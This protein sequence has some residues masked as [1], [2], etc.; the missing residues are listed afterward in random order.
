MKNENGIPHGEYCYDE[1]GLC[2]H[3]CINDNEPE[4]MNGYCK[5]LKIG[6]WMGDHG[7]GLIWD[8]C[9]ECGENLS[10]ESEFV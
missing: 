2:K 7:T 4:Q 5:Y 8:Q 3:W 6:D 9:K 1:E 10:D